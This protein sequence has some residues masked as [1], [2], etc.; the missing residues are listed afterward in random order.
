MGH[1]LKKILLRNKKHARAKVVK[2]VFVEFIKKHHL[3]SASFKALASWSGQ[4]VSL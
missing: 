3:A 4:D 2:Y 1:F